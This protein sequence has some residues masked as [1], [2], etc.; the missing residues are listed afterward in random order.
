MGVT[1]TLL[2]C[3]CAS[4]MRILPVVIFKGVRKNV[5]GW[6]PMCSLVHL[7]PKGWINTEQFAEWFQHFIECIS[8]HRL[9]VLFMDSH[10]SHTTPEILSKTSYNGIHLVT[11][12]SH[13]TLLLQ[14]L[15][16]GIYR[17]LKEG[18]RKEME[19]FLTEHHIAKPDLCDFNGLLGSTYCGAFQSATVC[20]S[21]TKTGIFHFN[22]DAISRW[23]SCSISCHWKQR[24]KWQWGWNDF[25]W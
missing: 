15:D 18:W 6:N 25:R 20:N 22:R 4:G 21:F 2:C 7:S 16:I 14:P 1:T 13:T 5:I 11:F 10:V 12:P 17:L 19:K 24:S 9:V 23:S 8:S 3:I